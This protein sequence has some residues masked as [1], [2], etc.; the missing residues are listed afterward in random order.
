MP[1]ALPAVLLFTLLPLL[2]ELDGAMELFDFDVC[3][4]TEA[5]TRDF[6]ILEVR[7]AWLV[8][9]DDLE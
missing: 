4:V 9:A 3:P 1:I 8:A 6:D 7:L 5:P 2:V